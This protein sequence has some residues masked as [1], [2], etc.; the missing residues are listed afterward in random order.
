MKIPEKQVINVA[1]LITA[2]EHEWKVKLLL[3]NEGS[4]VHLEPEHEQH[5]NEI[6]EIIEQMKEFLM[7]Q[8]VTICILLASAR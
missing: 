8:H 1:L 7:V 4:I 2:R 3:D 6:E 5:R